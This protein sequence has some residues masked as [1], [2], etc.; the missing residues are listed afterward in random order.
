MEIRLPVGPGDAASSTS[1]SCWPMR[2]TTV[3]SGRPT[4]TRRSLAVPGHLGAHRLGDGPQ[5]HEQHAVGH[6]G[7]RPG[8]RRPARRTPGSPAAPA[9]RRPRPGAPGP[10]PRPRRPGRMLITSMAGTIWMDIPVNSVPSTTTSWPASCRELLLVAD[11]P[12]AGHG[13]EAALQVHPLHHRR[14][15]AGCSGPPR[16]RGSAGLDRGGNR[17]RLDRVSTGRSASP[18]MAGAA[19][20]V[21]NE[22]AERSGFLPTLHRSYLLFTVTDGSSRPRRF[23]GGRKCRLA[24]RP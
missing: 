1:A 19:D 22:G 5:G 21:I 11:Q 24:S 13:P 16:G 12:H 9:R 7:A 10:W 6:H 2:K 17:N 15:A 23:N 20:T 8:R 4:R 18:A 14:P 3:R